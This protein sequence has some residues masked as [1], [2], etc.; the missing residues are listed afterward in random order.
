MTKQED[1]RC[2]K[3]SRYNAAKK[4]RDEAEKAELDRE[5]DQVANDIIE[6]MNDDLDSIIGSD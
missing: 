4:Y 6:S 2:H 5:L 1:V 3:D